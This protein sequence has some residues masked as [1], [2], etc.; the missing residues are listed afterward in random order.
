MPSSPIVIDDD[1]PPPSSSRSIAQSAVPQT[2]PPKKPLAGRSLFFVAP[3]VLNS[4]RKRQYQPL[5]KFLDKDEPETRV[6]EVIGEFQDGPTLYYFAR[7]DGGIA[8]KFLADTFAEKHPKLLEK[9]E[10]QKAE[11]TLAKFDPSGTYVHPLSRVKVKIRISSDQRSRAS[12]SEAGDSD[13]VVPDSQDEDSET[14][15]DEDESDEYGTRRR[16]QPKRTARN[17]VKSLPFSPKK[18]RS[19]KVITVHGSDSEGSYSEL[20]SDD[21]SPQLK[22]RSTR[23]RKMTEIQ[24]ESDRDYLDELSDAQSEAQSSDAPGRTIKVHRSRKKTAVRRKSV[25][26]AYG[27]IRDIKTIGEDPY[28]DDEENEV[29]RRHR[30]HCEKCH[31]GRADQLLQTFRKTSKKKGKKRKRAD[32]E[33]DFEWSDEEEKLTTLG[34]WLQCLKCPVSAHWGCLASTQQDE[35]LRAIRARD[36]EALIRQ[37]PEESD[38]PLPRKRP[39]LELEETTE[40]LCGACM[41]GGI[42]LGCTETALE[43]DPSKIVEQKRAK[44][45]DSDVIMQEN[46]EPQ[47][48]RSIARELLFRCFTCKRLCHYQ[49]LPKPLGFE[50]DTVA[51]VAEYYQNSKNWL[52]ADCSS[53]KYGLDKII[54]WR[55][56]PAN[57]VEAAGRKGE[58]AANYKSQLPREYLVK[59]TGR[60]YRRLDW[61][62]HM[63]LLSTH[64][65]KLK[66]FVAGG[67]K[68]ELLEEPLKD[69]ENVMEVDEASTLPS[70]EK[71]VESTANF[72]KPEITLVSPAAAMPDAERR[73]PLHWKTVHRVL[74]VNLWRIPVKKG[75]PSASTKRKQQK[76][77]L[78]SEDDEEDEE[79]A[80]QKKYVF[81]HGEQPAADYTKTVDEWE[82]DQGVLQKEDVKHVVWVFIKWDE[83]GYEEATWDAPPRPGEQGYENF[84]QA[85][86]KFIE[87]RSVLLPIRDQQYWKTFDNRTKDGYRK[88]HILKDAADLKLGQ[89][90]NLKLMPFQVDGFNWLCNNWWNHQHC[91]LADEMGLGK[92]VQIVS[93]LGNIKKLVR[94]TPALVV[95]PN[96]TI[97]NWVREFERW[98]PDLRV[99]PFYGE[100]NARDVIKRFELFHENVPRGHL[101]T[102][103]NVLITT[104]EAFTN[105]KD[106]GPVFKSQP[107][108]EVLVV[109]EGQRL[110]SDS[111]LLFRKLN[112]LKTNHRIIMTGTPLNNNIRELFNLMN[113]LDPSEWQDLEALEK[114]H[115]E[116]TEELVKDLH[117]RLRPYFLRR[118]KSEVLELPPKNEVIV[119][120]SMA[121]VQKEVYRSILTNNLEVLKGLTQPSSKQNAPAK[122]RINNVLM[123]LRKCLQHPYLYAQDLEPRDLSPQETHGKLI[124]AS[125]KLRFLKI[126]LPKLKQ[127]GHRILLFSQFVI[128]LNVVEDFLVGEGYK[129]LRLDG[130]TK[131]SVRQKSMDDF[132]K[133]N[134]DFFIFLLTT[135]A[136]GVGINLF[137]ADTVIIFDP[138]FNPHQ[139]LQAIA[140]AYRYGQKKTCMVFKLIVKDSA[141]ERIMQVGKK[142]LVLDH[143]IVQKMDDDEEN[144]GEDVKSILTYGAQALFES[145]QTQAERD[146]NY[147]EQDIEKLIDKTQSEAVPEGPET[148]GGGLSFSFAK[149]WAADKD[150]LEEV[151]EEDQADSWAQALQKLNE[152]KDLEQQRQL[153]ESGR[154]AKRKAATLANTRMIGDQEKSNSNKKRAKSHSSLGS[155]YH[156]SEHSDIEMDSESGT[157]SDI[158][159]FNGGSD[160]AKQKKPLT[161]RPN[162]VPGISRDCGLCGQQHGHGQCIMIEKSENLAEYRE[163]L[164]LHA[165]DEPWEERR[166]AVEAI[167]EILMARGHINLIGGQ[168]LRLLPVPV[169]GPVP[170]AQKKKKPR[171]SSK[172]SAA[173]DYTLALLN[174][175][176]PKANNPVQIMPS[177]PCILCHKNEPHHYK[178]CSVVRAGSKSIS[179]AIQHL[180]SRKD[181]SLHYAINSL[182]TL[183]AKAKAREIANQGTGTAGPSRAG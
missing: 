75:K 77:L 41:R 76:V 84:K 94:A 73:I 72:D 80:L 28:S 142:K 169:P 50:E 7:Y 134:S 69:E 63:W 139:D 5:N 49:H 118:I 35:V 27:H 108:W 91:I 113:F 21:N 148:T 20:G 86:E 96:S 16:A 64:P 11:S 167:D 135:R 53:F 168:P 119:P 149:I 117:N 101:K 128:A 172:P 98:A 57:A 13:E 8:H 24:L 140:R 85:F 177:S 147:S 2:P 162:G 175:E 157:A 110:K 51:E 125:A 37:A 33:D 143:L 70:F 39:G 45:T 171:P 182:R 115:E 141:E 88:Q 100:K 26:P 30:P 132:N 71:N 82:K 174:G 170:P 9:Y 43:M 158:E 34:G 154:G 67:T 32:E 126:L 59:W 106:T 48:D 40:F 3:P 111:S 89:Q 19:R 95:V 150:N 15:D 146:I 176:Q 29:L 178:D 23:S 92:T 31:Q 17:K 42:C 159:D 137:T 102:K 52:C 87:S 173:K 90:K 153:A 163:M 18:T 83:L 151:I 99:V 181:T 60:S 166:A 78:P 6:N 138:D 58:S 104:Y 133:P 56:Y 144:G 116:L 160:K 79:E 65:G 44:N 54:A 14:D 123:Q 130:S 81:D 1:S 36:H 12:R 46:S 25:M 4:A 161:Q 145:E 131:G 55:P 93:F 68:V 109:D 183:L 112:E 97:T 180:E 165:H 152:A 22:R 103:F 114:Q 164:I 127:R 129:F 10:R 62:P 66:H 124:D 107:R 179:T 156:I 105:T 38:I 121:P 47:V 120:V 61:V 122:T 155:D 136:G 74:D